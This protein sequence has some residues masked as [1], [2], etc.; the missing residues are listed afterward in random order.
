MAEKQAARRI[1]L[2]NAGRIDPDSISDYKEAGGFSALRRALERKPEELFQEV[3]DSGLQGRG[4]AG[5]PTGVKEKL[6]E[7]SICAACGPKYVVCN[8]DEGEPGT[9]KDR[10]IMEQD[11]HLMVEG[12]I[13]SAYAIG[14]EQAYIYIRGEY[15]ES[16][17]RVQKAVENCYAAGY[18]GSD[19]LGS[20]FTLEAEIRLGAGS[21]LCGEELTLLESL[22]GK[23]GYPRIKPPYPAE[24]GLFGAPTL[25]NNVETF[26]HI[27]YV[28]RHG[29]D[30]Y[31]KL[32]TEDSPGTKIFTVSGDVAA[33]GYY[34]T[35]LGVTLRQL[36][37]EHCGGMKEGRSF[38]A[39]LV[40]GAAGSLVSGELLDV[41]LGY[42]SLKEYGAILGS[43]AVI[44]FD[45]TRDLAEPLRDVMEFFR[46]ESCGKCVPCRI[47]TAV[48]LELAEELRDA[49]AG[50][51]SGLL[52]RMEREAQ[53]MDATSLCPLGKSPILS[54]GTAQRFFGA[55]L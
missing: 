24:Y 44:V 50:S 55:R 13:I 3:I 9:F 22:E 38:K 47:G 54:L 45:E 8:A 41:P 27:P 28:V 21:Y 46:H 49:P 5:F 32:G 18:L 48:L 23:R 53:Y 10:A 11:P 7:E 52:D 37:D 16:I 12:L 42:K 1:A 17:R 43:G 40:G 51:R 19:I 25:I 30:S 14:A 15:S 36:I 34:E 29:A 35:E 26:A 2:A 6:T 4:G 31:R 33:P 39:A 20:G